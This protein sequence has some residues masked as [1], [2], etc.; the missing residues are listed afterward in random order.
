MHPLPAPLA[1]LQA[2]LEPPLMCSQMGSSVAKYAK[3]K[4]ELLRLEQATAVL[5]RGQAACLAALRAADGGPA[6]TAAA[7]QALRGALARA[8]ALSAAACA[9]AAEALAHMPVLAPCSGPALRWRPLPL[10]TWAEA[11]AQVAAAARQVSAAYREAYQ[12]EELDFALSLNVEGVSD[13]SGRAWQ[14]LGL[15]FVKRDAAGTCAAPAW[16]GPANVW[17]PAS[18][19]PT[20]TL[21]SQHRALLFTVAE[22]A[23]LLHAAQAAEAAAAAALDVPVS[24][25]APPALVN[26]A[27]LDSAATKGDAVDDME[28]GKLDA[29]RAADT[30][31]AAGGKVRPSALRRLAANPYVSSFAVLLLLASPLPLLKLT[32]DACWT[33][34]KA[35]PGLL[36]SGQAWRQGT[37]AGL[38]VLRA[39]HAAG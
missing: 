19:L 7:A 10:G 32:A 1:P 24:P 13:G 5:G 9:G 37:G 33:V 18:S 14:R 27:G 8:S 12:Q 22:A 39:V 16:L 6:P 25:A 17:P 2:R 28:S 34:A 26:G 35:V 30:A 11:Q 3:L 36:T 38:A 23:E 4:Q 20:H 15:E 29:G 31:S 21:H